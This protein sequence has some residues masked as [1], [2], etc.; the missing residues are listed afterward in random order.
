M[1]NNRETFNFK[2]EDNLVPYQKPPIK[3]KLFNTCGRYSKII[4]KGATGNHFLG[5]GNQ[6][7]E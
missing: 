5:L 6:L 3:F 1:G 4:E 2:C 7:C